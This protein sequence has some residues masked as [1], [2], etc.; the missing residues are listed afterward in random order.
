MEIDLNKKPHDGLN[1]EQVTAFKILIVMLF[2]CV[3]FFFTGAAMM[4][5]AQFIFK[6]CNI[7]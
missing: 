1:K 7:N 3:L 2:L 4:L 5:Y 6:G